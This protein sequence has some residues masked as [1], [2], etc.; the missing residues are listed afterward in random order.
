MASDYGVDVDDVHIDATYTISGS[1]TVEDLPDDVSDS[2]LVDILEQSIADALGVHSKD[3]EVK[4]EFEH[5][6]R[7]SY[8]RRR[9]R[10]L[11]G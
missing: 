7:T 4:I 2:E 6:V 5:F 9:S 3:V 1:M 11:R 8:S 10:S